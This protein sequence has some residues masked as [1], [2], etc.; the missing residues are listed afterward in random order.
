MGPRGFSTLDFESYS[1]CIAEGSQ[2]GMFL[3][4]SKNPHWYTEKKGNQ[5]PKICVLVLLYIIGGFVS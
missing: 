3:T 1:V 5:D 4:F 2:R